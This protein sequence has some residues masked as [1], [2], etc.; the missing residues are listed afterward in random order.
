MCLYD[1]SRDLYKYVIKHMVSSQLYIFNYRKCKILAHIRYRIKFTYS[2]VQFSCG[3]CHKAAKTQLACLYKAPHLSDVNLTSCLFN[4]D[5]TCTYEIE[6][7]QKE[8]ILKKEK[9]AKL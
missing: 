7:N 5:H 3:K 8:I 2:N 9:A 6:Q 4:F 1:K